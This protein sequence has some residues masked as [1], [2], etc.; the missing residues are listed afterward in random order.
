M[1][2]ASIRKESKRS[3]YPASRQGAAQRRFH[4][5]PLYLHVHQAPGRITDAEQGNLRPATADAG[6]SEMR[7]AGCDGSGVEYRMLDPGLGTNEP[8]SPSRRRASRDIIT[9]LVGPDG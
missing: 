6:T 4:S 5:R 9:T 7:R 2:L 1:R 8:A 3:S